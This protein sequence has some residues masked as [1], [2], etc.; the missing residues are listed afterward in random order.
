MSQQLSI[1]WTPSYFERICRRYCQTKKVVGSTS[2]ASHIADSPSMT[3]MHR[4]LEKLVPMQD[5]CLQVAKL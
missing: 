1:T 2:G 5:D 4:E 3:G